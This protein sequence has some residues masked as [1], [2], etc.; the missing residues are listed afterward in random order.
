MNP[1]R[2]LPFDGKLVNRHRIMR[3]GITYGDL[4]PEGAGD[5]GKDRGVIF[6]CLQASL[7]RGFEF[8]QSQW[9]N[10]GNAF[11]LA[12]DQD[13]IVGPHDTDGPAKM[14]VPGHPPF[15]LG[16]LSGR[17]HD[18]RRRV[19]LHARDQ[20][21][22]APRARLVPRREKRPLALPSAA[23]RGQSMIWTSSSFSSGPWTAIS[24]TSPMPAT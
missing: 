20:R 10:G 5:D 8:V 13:V 21:A 9:A 22:T 2:S 17:R 18:T 11:R 6:M 12:E 3:R 19:L 16:P 7:A 14:T 1:R 15:F 4:L 24:W 23:C